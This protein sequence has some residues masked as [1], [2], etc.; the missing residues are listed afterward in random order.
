M[1]VTH[2]ECYRIMIEWKANMYYVILKNF[3]SNFFNN[4]INLF[5]VTT[6]TLVITENGGESIK[7]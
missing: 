7:I 2:F 1:L 3:D 6:I 4:L 5:S